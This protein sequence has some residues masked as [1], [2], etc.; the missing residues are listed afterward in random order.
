TECQTQSSS[1]SSDFTSKL[2]NIE[3]VSPADYIIASVMDTTAHQTSSTVITTTPLPPTSIIPPT[4]QVTTTS[5]PTT[6][7]PTTS[8]PTTT[9]TRLGFAVQMAFQSYAIDFEKEAQ[10]EPERF[11]EVI[12]KSVKEMVKDEVKSQLTKIFPKKIY[13]FATL[14]IESTI[15]E[16]YENVVLAKSS[17]QPTSTYEA[18]ASLI[19][20]EL[21]KILLDKMEKSKSY[22]AAPKHKELYDGLIKSYNVDKGLFKAYGQA[23]SLKRGC[24]DN[25]KYEDPSAGSDRGSKRRKTGK[26][27]ESSKEQNSKGSKSTSSSKGTSRSPYKL[28]GKSVHAEE[29]SYDSAFFMNKLKI[30][31]LTQEI[32]VGPAYNL[33]KGSCKSFMELEYHFEEDYKAVNDQLDWN[34]SE[35]QVYPFDLSKP[36]SLIQDDRGRQVISV[37]YFINNDLE[38]LKG[39]SSSRKYTTSTTKTKA[40]IYDNIQGIKEMKKILNLEKDVLFD[41][42]VALQMFTRRIVILKRVK[43]LQ[44][45]VEI[46]QKK[47]NITNP[48]TYRPDIKYL[49][50]YTAYNNPQGIIYLNKF[51]RNRL[52]RLDKLYKFCNGTLNFVKSAL[53]D[54]ANNMRME[55]LPKRDWS[56]LDRKSSR[57]AIKA[58]DELLFKRRLMRNI[59]RCVGGRE[60]ENDFRLLERTI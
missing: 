52:M 14:L 30:E 36:L 42:N 13:D 34:N 5:A 1:V 29:P 7:A 58:I 45:G 56:R 24:D 20:F 26:D 27:A 4:Q 40:A 59:E 22:Q 54:I 32:L 47:L 17:S 43:D 53:H 41:L 18:A 3:N 21:K 28:T 37:D 39:G 38:Y 35:G 55:Y 25:D 46:Y 19:E 51:D 44:L 8:A 11:I 16:S 15:A 57:I 12:D 2:L 9:P 33:L 6:S 23:Y 49:T 48:D 31:N 60:Y 10:V 50:P